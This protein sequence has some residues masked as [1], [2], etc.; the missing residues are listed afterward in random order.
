MDVGAFGNRLGLEEAY[1]F[2]RGEE[3][4]VS[5]KMNIRLSR[6]LDF[7]VIVDHSDNMGFFPD[8]FEG[9]FHILSDFIGKDW[10]NRVMV[11]E[12]VGVAL[13]LISKFSQGQFSEALIYVL[14]SKPYKDAWAK[15]VKAVEQFNEPGTFTAF[16]GYEWTSLVK[17]ANMHR[18]VIY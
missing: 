5:N 7:L 12:G 11:G 9:V 3:I 14:D 1:R 15:T 6:S 2:A 10:Y 17:G 8:L 18:V 4:T 13:E 16:I